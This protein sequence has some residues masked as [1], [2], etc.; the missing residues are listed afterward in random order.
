MAPMLEPLYFGLGAVISGL[1][2]WGW[3]RRTPQEAAAPRERY[4]LT[5]GWRVSEFDDP[6]LVVRDIQG[7]QVPAGAKVL[8]SG[9]V[10]S[11]VQAGCDVRQ[12]AEVR[13]EFV[14]DRARGRALLWFG[15]AREGSMGLITTDATLVARLENEFKSL[16]DKAEPYVERY[17]IA[18]LSGRTGVTVE[19]EGEVQEVIPWRDQWMMRL[20]DQGHVLGVLVPKDPTA[21]ETQRVRVKGRLEKD[22]GGY[23]VLRAEDVRSVM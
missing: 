21:L 22:R 4:Q 10:D 23:V 19:T 9:L 15:G 3:M 18:E 20:T 6:V 7:V 14:L 1:G 12:A 8:A 17:K 11:S 2:V 16:W 13:A 5:T